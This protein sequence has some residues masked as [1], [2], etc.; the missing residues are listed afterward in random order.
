[1]KD[2]DL[3]KKR[4]DECIRYTRRWY[5]SE[6]EDYV[7]YN[8]AT[9]IKK[10]MQ[11]EFNKLHKELIANDI[12][13]RLEDKTMDKYFDME[14][15]RTEL[16]NFDPDM[17]GFS[18]VMTHDAGYLGGLREGL[19]G[20]EKV[21]KLKSKDPYQWDLIPR[22]EALE[23]YTKY[24]LCYIAGIEPMDLDPED[25]KSFQEWLKSEI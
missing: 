12:E 13:D 19:N 20:S 22:E 15:L 5:L 1:M 17:D 14:L 7:D 16:T 24:L 4:I 25:V 6:L 3:F 8:E 11:D 2:N 21:E 9:V 10:E 23:G 18:D